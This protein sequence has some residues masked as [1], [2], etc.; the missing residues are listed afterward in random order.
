MPLGYG[1][2]PADFVNA[3]LLGSVGAVGSAL[4]ACA[5]FLYNLRN[6]VEDIKS[7]RRDLVIVGGSDAPLPLK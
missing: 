6:A 3:Y 7:G 4:G 1:Q 2:M 5:T